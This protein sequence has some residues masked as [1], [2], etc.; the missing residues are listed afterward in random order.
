LTEETE[1][2]H[3]EFKEMLLESPSEL[4]ENDLI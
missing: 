3:K 2:P 4:K 1:L